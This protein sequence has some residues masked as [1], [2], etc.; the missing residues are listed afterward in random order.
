MDRVRAFDPRDEA[1]LAVLWHDAWHMAHGAHVPATLLPNRQLDYFQRTLQTFAA[2]TRVIGQVG[3]PFGFY[4][5][6]GNYVD[7]L[8]VGVRKR[9]YGAALLNDAETEM[10]REGIS[11]GE[12]GCLVENTPARGFYEAQGWQLIHIKTEAILEEHGGGTLNDCIYRK[13]L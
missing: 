2:Q 12:L 7:R 3:A 1:A 9:G 5:R 10:R 13:K 8:F 11:E 6:I 4:L